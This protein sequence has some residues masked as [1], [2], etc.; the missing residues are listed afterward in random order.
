MTAM[1]KR[2]SRRAPLVLG[3]RGYRA[4]YP[5]NTLLAFREAMAAGADGV[6]CDVQKTADGQYV[7]IHDQSVDR[8]TG[9]HGDVARMS[10]AELQGLDFGSGETIPLLG[11][12]LRELPPGSYLDLELKEETL[13]PEDAEPIALLLDS[14]RG[15]RDL[16]ISS[17]DAS[18][19]HPFKKR[20]FTVGYL[21]GKEAA[22]RGF[23]GFADVLLRLRPQYINLPVDII[24]KLGPRWASLLFRALRGLGFSLLFW[25]V[26]TPEMAAAVKPHA[27]MIVTDEVEKACNEW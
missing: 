25:T 13:R 5:E 4:R 17:F 2:H 19:L 10:L 15:R 20:G 22:E 23:I 12:L 1:E 18:L 6:E 8:V 14:C 27:R 21:V 11:D 9:V 16:M 3:H 26:N 24:A 7:V